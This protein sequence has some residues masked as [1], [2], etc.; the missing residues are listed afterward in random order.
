MRHAVL[1]FLA[2][3]LTAC[4]A[5][6]RYAPVTQPQATPGE[7]KFRVG[8]HYRFRSSWGRD[9]FTDAAGKPIYDSSEPH[10]RIEQLV[11]SPAGL[12][13]QV[14]MASGTVGFCDAQKFRGEFYEG[15]E[16]K[17]EQAE[18]KAAMAKAEAVAE[19]QR[20]IDKAFAEAT[21]KIAAILNKAGVKVGSTVW[22]KGQGMSQ[23][24]VREI[25]LD[26]PAKAQNDVE[27]AAV[28]LVGDAITL[29]LGDYR[30]VL[31][32]PRAA[33]SKEVFLKLPNWSPSVFKAIR[34]GDILLGMTDEQVLLSKGIPQRGNEIND[35]RGRFE[36]WVYYNERVYLLNN[37]VTSW[38]R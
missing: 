31:K 29:N 1:V 7:L 28:Y 24:T 33:L 18:A 20:K 14:R 9:V 17:R 15:F 10:F 36:Q 2:I 34:A 25:R 3:I 21:E 19:N 5:Q 13:Y 22:E 26:T 6:P 23:L 30:H 35:S 12:R 37:R 27:R 8:Q 38:T 11:E 16:P 4:A 32:A